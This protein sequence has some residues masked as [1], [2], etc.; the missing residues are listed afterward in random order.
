MLERRLPE[1]PGALAQNERHNRIGE[2]SVQCLELER[3]EE[4]LILQGAATGQDILRRA[5]AD[6]RAVLSVAVVA[7]AQVTAA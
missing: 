1:L 6:P 3:K 4:S 2:L 5:D 7:E